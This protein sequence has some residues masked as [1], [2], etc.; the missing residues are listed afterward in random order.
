MA[1]PPQKPPPKG[2]K[3]NPLTTKYG[4]L[5]GWGWLAV[6]VVGYLLY[7]KFSAS[8]SSGT[9]STAGGTAAATNVPNE[10]IT[11]PSGATYTG[12]AGAAPQG[13]NWGGGTGTSWSSTPGTTGTSP[14]PGPGGNAGGTPYPGYTLLTSNV[15]Q[16]VQSDLAAGTPVEYSANSG[17]PLVPV[18]QP[19]GAGTGWLIGGQPAS[20]VSGA[21]GTPG[22]PSGFYV[23][24]T[25]A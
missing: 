1:P 22:S 14:T 4:P 15:A 20:S 6:V 23:Q 9:A 16:S 8:S 21:G 2:G 18:T 19:A 25:A 24:Q 12:P 13:F 11:L 7:R 3:T 17:A 5:P 10:T